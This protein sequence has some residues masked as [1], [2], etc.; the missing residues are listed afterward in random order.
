[1]NLSAANC[2]QLGEFRLDLS[3]RSLGRPGEDPV[4]LTGRAFDVLAFLVE[5]RHRVVGK[6]EVMKAVWPRVVV[7]ENNLTQAISAARRALGD[8]WGP[9]VTSPPSRG[10]DTSTSAMCCPSCSLSRRRSRPLRS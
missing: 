5:N 1:M 7:E 8:S 3:R 9:R 2:Y 10:G 6:D 4:P